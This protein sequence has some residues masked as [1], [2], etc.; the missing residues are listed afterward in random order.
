MMAARI[1]VSD[2]AREWMR[3]PAFKAEYDALEEEF[4][5]AT[6]KILA[7]PKEAKLKKPMAGRGST[8]S[9]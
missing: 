2:L 5:L 4:A 9:V 8:Q 6:A 3:D 7:D 1:K